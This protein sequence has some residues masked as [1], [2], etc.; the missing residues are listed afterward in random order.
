VNVAQNE[1]SPKGTRITGKHGPDNR[2]YQLA[3]PTD[4]VVLVVAP[5]GSTKM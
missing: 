4:Y 1:R 5:V 3:V 2:T